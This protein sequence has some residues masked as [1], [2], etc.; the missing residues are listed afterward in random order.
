MENTVVDS[1]RHFAAGLLHLW[2]IVSC[3]D[4]FQPSVTVGLSSFQEYWEFDI[5]SFYFIFL[6]IPCLFEKAF[7][8]LE[9]T[10]LFC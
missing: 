5:L 4:F 9:G 10:T 3:L 1:A 7:F 8:E 6:L 2:V